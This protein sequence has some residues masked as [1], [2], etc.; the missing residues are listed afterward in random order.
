M[1]TITETQAAGL[2]RLNPP[3]EPMTYQQFLDWVDEETH[4]EWVNGKVVFM[5]PVSREHALI[6]GFLMKLIMYFVELRDLGEVYDEPFQMKT[7]LS[8][9]APDVIFVAKKN[10]GRL[11]PNYLDDAADLAVEIISPDS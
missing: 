11:K 8:G 7:D 2:A 6:K 9:R 4:V 5:S 1:P 3:P 10:L